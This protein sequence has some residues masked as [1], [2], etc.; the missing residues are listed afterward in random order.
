[1]CT[2]LYP[3]STTSIPSTLE[4]S[5]EDKISVGLDTEAKNFLADSGRLAGKRGEG[6]SDIL[7]DVIFD[8]CFLSEGGWVR[9]ANIKDL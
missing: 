7:D 3:P 4:T 2:K 5:A 1:M 9:H 6:T 8:E